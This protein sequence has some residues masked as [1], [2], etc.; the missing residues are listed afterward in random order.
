V[1]SFVVPAFNNPRR[2]RTCLSSLVD[3]DSVELEVICVDN[4]IDIEAAN[5]NKELCRIDSRIR[6]EWT[7]DRTIITGPHTRCL[8]TA[9]EIG[10]GL[11]TGDWLAFPN[12]DSAYPS[13]FAERMIGYAD[14]NNLELVYCDF[15]LGGPTMD[16][17]LISVQ[18]HVCGI[19]KTAFIMKRSWF[20][21]FPEKRERYSCAD[22]VLIE[23]LLARGIRHGAFRQCLVTH[24]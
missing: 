13:V 16:Y 22:G 24:N 11:A 15:L 10:V 18:P 2:L 14:G 6:Y 7:A 23:S 20:E 21:C 4:T 5:E 19:D 9:T 1:I 8:Y 12:Q 17:R 3:Q